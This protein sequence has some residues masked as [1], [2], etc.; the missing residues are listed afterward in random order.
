MTKLEQQIKEAHKRRYDRAIAQSKDKTKNEA[1]RAASLAEA[2]RIKR[3]Y[4]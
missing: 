2:K 3:A 4:L 1:F